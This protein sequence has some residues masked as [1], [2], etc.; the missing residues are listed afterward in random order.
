MAAIRYNSISAVLDKYDI[1]QKDLA[2]ILKVGKDTVSRWCVNKNQPS[3]PQLYEIAKVIKIDIRELLRST[4]AWSKE[5][6]LSPIEV[7][8]NKKEE[9]KRIAKAKK[10]K[11]MVKRIP[12]RRY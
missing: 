7:F 1:Y 3:I 4:E 5:E 8:K 12:K 6:G 2:E 11:S 10:K 9:A